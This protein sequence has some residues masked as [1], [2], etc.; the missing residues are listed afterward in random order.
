MSTAEPAPKVVVARALRACG[1]RMRQS[2]SDEHT[3]CWQA[4]CSRGVAGGRV[5]QQVARVSWLSAVSRFGGG[6]LQ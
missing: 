1:H 6:V 5:S 3:L 2:P 4:R